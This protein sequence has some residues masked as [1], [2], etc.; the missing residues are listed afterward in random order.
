MSATQPAL[1]TLFIKILAVGAGGGFGA[2]L[3]HAGVEALQSGLGLPPFASV[4]TVNVLGCFAIGFAFV[5]IEGSYRRGGGSRLRHL[6]VSREL[7]DRNWWPEGDATL[8]AVDLFQFDLRAEILAGFFITG[9]L[10]ALTTFSL[11][12]IQNVELLQAGAPGW[13]A[14]NAIGSVTLGFFAVGLGLRVGHRWVPRR[15]R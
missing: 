14:F 7:E 10:G 2:V 6:P 4:M 12:S 5:L 3:R 11:F 15:S 8:P 13:A 1:T 9:L